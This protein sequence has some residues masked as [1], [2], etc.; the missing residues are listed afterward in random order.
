MSQSSIHIRSTD[1]ATIKTIV[2]MPLRF[3]EPT[4]PMIRMRISPTRSAS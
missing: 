1:G 2:G 3:D 4:P